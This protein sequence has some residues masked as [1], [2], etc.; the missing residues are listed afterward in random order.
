MAALTPL[1][2]GQSHERFAAI[3]ALRADGGE[4]TAAREQA[5]CILE[6]WQVALRDALLTRVG[7]GESAAVDARG[8][9]TDALLVERLLSMQTA[10]ERAKDYV[11]ANVAPKLALESVALV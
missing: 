8:A 3:E 6:W 10:L 1:M 5:M 2:H 4:S 9:S 7:A 11:R